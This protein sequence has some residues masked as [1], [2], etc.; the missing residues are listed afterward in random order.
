MKGKKSLTAV[1]TACWASRSATSPWSVATVRIFLIHGSSRVGGRR[2]LYFIHVWWYH[3]L[4]NVRKKCQTACALLLLPISVQPALNNAKARFL[5]CTWV[6][7]LWEAT[8]Q[9][10]LILQ[11]R[12]RKWGW[13][14]LTPRKGDESIEKQALHWNPQ[15]ARRRGR[16]KQTWKRT[17]LEEATKAAKHRARLRGWQATASDGDA[18]QMPYVPY[19][20]KGYTAT[21]SNNGLVTSYCSSHALRLSIGLL[22][23]WQN[24]KFWNS[25]SFTLVQ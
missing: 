12:V 17:V 3:I 23:R 24:A 16:P 10:P 4:D 20:T 11:I 2:L 19:R 6:G 1:R 18:S 22:Q 9:K 5:V 25:A 13:I 21:V 14:S 8:G 7:E 15:W